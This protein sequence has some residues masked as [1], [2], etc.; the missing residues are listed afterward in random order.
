[1]LS[2]LLKKQLTE[3][4]RNYFY[5][6]KKNKMRSRGATAMYI[7]LYVLLMAGVLG[8]MFAL[9]AVGICAPMAAAG[10]GWLYYLVMGLIAVL[11]GAFGSVF[12]TY[13]SLYLSKDNDLLLSMPIPV[14][15][16]MASRLLGVYL[17]GLMY[18]GVATVPAVIVYWIV[19]PVTAGTVVGGV[20]TVLLVS[21]IVMVL[22]C[23]LG[24]VVAR[25]SL[26]L[27][28][29]S[30]ITVILSLAFLAAYYFVYYKV[31][32]LITLLAENAAVY[33]AKIRGSAYLL[34]LFGSV[35]P[36]LALVLS[37]A[38]RFV[39]QFRRQMRR[40]RCAQKTMGLYAARGY[41]DKV[42][43]AGRVFLAMI[44]WSL[45]NAMETAASM[46]ARGYGRGHR[47]NFSLFRFTARDGALLAVC[48]AL[49]GVVAVGMA[50]GVT[51]F[52]F[53][54]R[55]STPELTPAALAVYIAFGALSLLPF[56]IEV[57]EAIVW[58]Y[59]RSRI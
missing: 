29:K 35:I 19:A 57:R 20:L 12:S 21:V 3:I 45:E 5:D 31:Q 40:V 7:A 33:G 28:N 24:W 8:G 38:L 55:V 14:R 16:V 2:V 27:K 43:S 50:A 42:R 25:I 13:S 17:L 34:Y 39:P 9:L 54:P 53:Y 36:K 59:Y 30:F 23:L 51:A 49:M 6:P 46:K 22:S 11:L 47:T 32:G 15:Y 37:M 56:T 10:V 26:K 18:S 44:A 48:A 4:F 1:M 58:R 41:T 52:D